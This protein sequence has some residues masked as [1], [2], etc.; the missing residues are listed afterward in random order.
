MTGD[1]TSKNSK[2]EPEEQP[3][4]PF[5]FKTSKEVIFLKEVVERSLPP[6]TRFLTTIPYKNLT[7]FVIATDSKMIMVDDGFLPLGVVVLNVGKPKGFLLTR[8]EYEVPWEFSGSEPYERY[9]IS[10]NYR[11][12]ELNGLR[13][14]GVGQ[15]YRGPMLTGHG[16]ANSDI[17]SI[18]G[19]PVSELIN[20]LTGVIVKRY[21]L[22]L[23]KVLATSCNSKTGALEGVNI[24]VFYA[25][26]DV[27][28]FSNLDKRTSARGSGPVDLFVTWGDRWMA[29]FPGREPVVYR[30]KAEDV[31]A[32]PPLTR[33]EIRYLLQKNAEET[34]KARAEE[35]LKSVEESQKVRKSRVIADYLALVKASFVSLGQRVAR[36]SQET[37]SS[38]PPYTTYEVPES[39]DD[40]QNVE[41]TIYGI[42]GDIEGV[43]AAFYEGALTEEEFNSYMLEKANKLREKWSPAIESAK[44]HVKTRQDAIKI[45]DSLL[46]DMPVTHTIMPFRSLLEGWRK[47]LKII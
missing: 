15:P 2:D 37:D 32:H 25:L 19:V 21:G 1:K 20:Y 12:S 9:G 39:I 16:D 6:N 35:V 17:H 40:R 18:E 22:V 23:R 31:A 24:P 28:P 5:E 34:E 29:K 45:L 4:A 42:D 8:E 10:D 11:M 7:V 33:E 3:Q 44:S 43:I 47:E 13:L 30:P 46:A 38:V 27:R 26:E 41:N 36:R 14:I